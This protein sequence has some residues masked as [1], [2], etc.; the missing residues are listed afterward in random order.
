[1]EYL[2]AQNKMIAKEEIPADQII[3]A[4][5]KNVLV[6]GGGDTGSDCI[7]TAN[8][9]GAANILQIEILPK[10]AKLED[11]E[12]P[13]PN[14]F[15]VVLKTSSSHLEGCERRWSLNTKRFIG[16]DGKLTAVE[17]VEVA[18]EKDENG[19][20][21]MKEVGEP[22]ILKMDLVFLAL[23]FVHPIQEGLL[24]ELGIKTDDIRHNVATDAKRA[25]NVAKVFGAGDCVSGQS[26]VVTS[27]ASGRKTAQHIDEYLSK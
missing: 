5:G 15:P 7:G 27:I 14:P 20:H 25:T 12:N 2:T 18:W 19:K 9:Q 24:K 11:I 17:L 6:I 22:E 8:R 13:W 4:K 26:L 3:D 23:G 10:P 21:V 1:M 16:E